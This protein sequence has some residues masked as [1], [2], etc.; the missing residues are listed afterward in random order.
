MIVSLVGIFLLFLFWK[1]GEIELKW[2]LILTALVIAGRFFFMGIGSI[3]AL[4]IIFLMLR[5][6]GEKIR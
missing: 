2:K 3:I 6:H 5:W 1:N 4:I